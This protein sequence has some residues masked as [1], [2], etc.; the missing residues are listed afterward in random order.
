MLK[1]KTKT[2]PIPSFVRLLLLLPF[3]FL[4][5]HPAIAQSV[6]TRA[7]SVRGA[8]NKYRACYDVYFYDLS[9]AVYPEERFIRG[10]NR[11]WLE[12]QE[13]MDILQVDLHHLLEIDSIRFNGEPLWHARDSNAVFI[14]F[15]KKVRVSSR[16]A[17][18]IYYS[19]NPLVAAKPPWQGGFVWRKDKQGNDWV[20]VACQGIGASVWWPN[21]DHLADKPDSMRIRANIPDDL[22]CVANGILEDY[23]THENN[24]STYTW[25]VQYPINNYNVT[26]NIGDYEEFD[27]LYTSVSGEEIQLNYYVLSYNMDKAREHFK[28]V[29][30]MLD[31]YEDLFGP[32]PFPKD[33]YA[34]VETP[35]WGMEH[36]SAIAYG[37]NY[38]NNEWGFDYIIIHESAHEYWGNNIS[39]K[40]IADLWVHESFT[41]YTE[42]LFLERLSGHKTATEYL[43]TQREL[44]K[45]KE[46]MQGPRD[47]NYYQRKDSDIYYKGAWMLHTLRHV[48]HNDSLWFALLK[49]IQTTYRKKTV[50]TEDITGYIQQFTNLKL[51][52]FFEQYLNTTDIPVLAY[53]LKEKKEGYQISYRWENVVDDFDMPIRV[54]EANNILKLTPTTRWQKVMVEKGSPEDFYVPAD[55]YLIEVSAQ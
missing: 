10:H 42:S 33:G 7:D 32:Y 21:K 5:E 53:K 4:L 34:L 2:N 28:Q 3:V 1:R 20:G 30:T 12:T 45:N 52:R 31:I 17:L 55:M 38:Q 11:I 6:F 29:R 44:I 23:T 8:Y 13:D 22:F 18:D 14:H 24:R 19:G 16:I 40:D 25:K 49:N 51:E 50:T 36:Q 26:I 37:N 9:I 46:P 39:V 35:Y 41:T 15:S 48:L 47:V 54:V 43:K 27:E